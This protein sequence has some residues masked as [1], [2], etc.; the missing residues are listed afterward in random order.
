[1]QGAREAIEDCRALSEPWEFQA[2]VQRNVAAN[3]G[4][5]LREAGLMVQHAAEQAVARLAELCPAEG[6][7]RD[8]CRN[9]CGTD[10]AA[11]A[12][13]ASRMCSH[14]LGQDTDTHRGLDWRF[15]QVDHGRVR[16][17]VLG[18]AG[19][20]GTGEGNDSRSRA[21][22]L[23]A[24]VEAQH[25][26]AALLALTSLFEEIRRDAMASGGGHWGPM[27]GPRLGAGGGVV[28]TTAGRVAGP[29]W[30][31]GVGRASRSGGEL[32][33]TAA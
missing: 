20:L 27:W 3:A 18:N 28:R 16:E 6:D 1:M 19:E 24:L 33:G 5:D 9:T 4:M 21:Q 14:A 11:A 25:A 12:G 2:L 8:R 26:C 23:W 22:V 31:A 32:G 13:Q 10:D 17:I 7:A 30:G 29:V 15:G